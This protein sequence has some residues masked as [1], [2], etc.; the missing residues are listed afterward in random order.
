M[1]ADRPLLTRPWVRRLG[2]VLAVLALAAVFM[3][4]RSPHTVVD[5]ANRVWAC[6]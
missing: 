3:A 2:A 6:L 5:L 1:T 4:Y